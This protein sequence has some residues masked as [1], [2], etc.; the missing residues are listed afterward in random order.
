MRKPKENA[1]APG[2]KSKATRASKCRAPVTTTTSTVTMVPTHKA[3]V[4]VA[5]D[6]IRRYRSARFTSPMIVTT[7]MVSRGVIPFQM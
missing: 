2:G 1:K 6:V 4:M 3:T 7:S 5:I